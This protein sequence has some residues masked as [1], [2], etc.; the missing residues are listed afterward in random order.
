MHVWRAVPRP[1]QHAFN[2]AMHDA[3]KE[4]FGKLFEVECFNL[5]Q[6]RLS[7]HL[8]GIGLPPTLPLAAIHVLTRTD[9]LTQALRVWCSAERDCLFLLLEPCLTAPVCAILTFGNL[10]SPANDRAPLAASRAATSAR[11][12]S[13]CLAYP[14]SARAAGR[15]CE[16]C[17]VVTT[18]VLTH[19]RQ[20]SCQQWLSA[21]QRCHSPIDKARKHCY[22]CARHI[23]RARYDGIRDH[24]AKVAM[25]AGWHAATEQR[26]AA[27]IRGQ[28]EARLFQVGNDQFVLQTCMS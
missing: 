6:L 18:W 19:S 21:C 14:A 25:F 13:D 20:A 5:T 2:E 15:M 7:P 17:R 16:Q 11:R 28:E 8:G 10:L 22:V 4:A 26:T 9:G 1:R 27:D 24:V 3:L 23:M 12:C